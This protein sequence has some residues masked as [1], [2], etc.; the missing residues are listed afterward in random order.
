MKFHYPQKKSLSEVNILYSVAF[1]QSVK[2]K[3][4][5]P[6]SPDSN[7]SDLFQVEQP[8]NE[9]SPPRPNTPIVLHSTEVSGNNTV[10]MIT[11][12]SIA[13]PGPKI[14]TI[15]SDLNEPT[16]QYGYG[17]QPPKIPP[18]LMNLNLAPN[19][20]KILATMAVANSTAEGHNENYSPQSPEPSEPSPI[21]TPPMNLITIEGWE[22]PHTTTD[23]NTVYSDDEPSRI[24]FLPSSPFP[25]LPLRKLKRKLSL[26]ISFPK[27]GG[28]SKHV[29]KAC[30]QLLPEP[31]DIPSSLSTE[32]KLKTENF[33]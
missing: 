30:G 14:V 13:S 18:S 8:S 29:C 28:V 27:R 5:R 24:H 4:F 21:A 9:P 19:P 15:D 33:I 10:E 7:D 26:G 31:N 11:M 12:S 20:F 23:D 6:T 22:I 32:E 2:S 16:M 17:R 25:P 1:Y 3:I